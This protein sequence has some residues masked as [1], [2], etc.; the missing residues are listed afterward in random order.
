MA[1]K[2]KLELIINPFN[3]ISMKRIFKLILIGV[4]VAVIAPAC[5]I[6]KRVY[7]PGYHITWNTLKSSTNGAETAVQ[8]PTEKTHAHATISK[9]QTNA[10]KSILDNSAVTHV[11]QAS[12]KATV[13]VVEVETKNAVN[14]T[15]L[16][17]KKASNQ[18]ELKS[19][20]KASTAK[21]A[22]KNAPAN[23]SD[24]ELILLYLL[25]ILIPFVAVGIVTDWELRDVVINLLLSCLC[26]IPGVIHAFIK[27]RDNR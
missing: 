17:T 23:N 12:T 3:L 7:N 5:S 19:V 16:A 24:D 21:K 11:A 9:L 6:E 14:L 18:H 2:F 27:I 10:G 20:A 13:N 26:Y 15:P 25:A 4:S 22:L 8:T 1:L